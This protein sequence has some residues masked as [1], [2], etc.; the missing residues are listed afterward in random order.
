MGPLGGSMETIALPVTPLASVEAA[1]F[2]A[3]RTLPGHL[4]SRPRRRLGFELP[5]NRLSLAGPFR[6]AQFDAQGKLQ[7]RIAGQELKPALDVRIDMRIG[8]VAPTLSIAAEKI[9]YGSVVVHYK[10]LEKTRSFTS[11][12]RSRP[13]T[14]PAANRSGQGASPAPRRFVVD[15]DGDQLLLLMDRRGFTGGEEVDHNKK[16]V[17]RTSDEYKELAERGLVVEV[18]SRRTGVPERLIV[19]PEVGFGSDDERNAA[20]YGDLLA[21]HGESNDSV[22]YRISD[23]ARLLAF[24]GRAIAGDAGLG[25]IAATN[26]L[27]DVAIYDVATG[28]EVERVTLDHYVLAARFIPEKRQLLVLTATQHVYALDLPG[29]GMVASAAK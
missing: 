14:R 9:Q 2:S 21:I 28:K 4:R 1:R 29:A 18:I 12:P 8:K 27:Q 11:T 3:E 23:G 17:V 24:S 26:R 10:P 19:A 22:V 15:T 20:L 25:L 13:L 6:N 16:L 7:A 5:A